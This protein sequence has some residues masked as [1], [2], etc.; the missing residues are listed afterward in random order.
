MSTATAAADEAKMAE[1]E[2]GGAAPADMERGKDRSV[3][4][5]EGGLR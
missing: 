2:L 5:E 4:S 1:V 3:Q